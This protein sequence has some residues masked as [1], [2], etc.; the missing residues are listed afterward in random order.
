[1]LIGDMCCGFFLQGDNVPAPYMTFD[2][3][4]FSPDLL[5]EVFHHE[6]WKLISCAS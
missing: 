3:A 5:R 2:V 4:G 1:M 6:S